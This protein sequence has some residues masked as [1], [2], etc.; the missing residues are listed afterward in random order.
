[1]EKLLRDGKVAVLVSCGFGAGWSTWNT[2]IGEAAVFDKDIAEAILNGGNA[3]EVAERK[4]PKA[5]H[6]GVKGLE[7]EWLPIGTRFEI[8]EYDGSESLRIFGPDDG[9]I[10]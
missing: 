8:H 2:D 1:M 7:V 5:Y 3:L 10:A 6:G 9:Y 4:Y